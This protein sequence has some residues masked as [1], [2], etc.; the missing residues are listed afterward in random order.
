MEV[1]LFFFLFMHSVLEKSDKI[2]EAHIFTDFMKLY[3]IVSSV[4]TSTLFGCVGVENVKP[5]CNCHV[6]VLSGVGFNS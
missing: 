3:N 6:V 5:H 2:Q 1:K 4:C